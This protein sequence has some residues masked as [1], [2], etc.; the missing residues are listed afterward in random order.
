MS[1]GMT[2]SFLTSACDWESGGG[3]FPPGEDRDVSINVGLL[4]IHPPDVTA[5]LRIFY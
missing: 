3:Q 1:G 4:V 5:S 2:V